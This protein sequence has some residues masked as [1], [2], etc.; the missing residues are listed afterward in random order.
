M[1]QL[2]VPRDVLIS[3]QKILDY[4]ETNKTNFAVGE[5][6]TEGAELVDFA[7]SK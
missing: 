1:Q 7:K 5:Q 4:Y 6:V 3:P 2:K